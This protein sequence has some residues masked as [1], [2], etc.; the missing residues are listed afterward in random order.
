MLRD[1]AEEYSK[2]AE[3]LVLRVWFAIMWDR[4]RDCTMNHR[5]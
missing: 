5:L 4:L 1:H 2:V 3:L